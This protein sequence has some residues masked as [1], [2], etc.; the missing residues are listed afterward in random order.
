MKNQRS[1]ICLF[2]LL[3]CFAHYSIAAKNPKPKRTRAIGGGVVMSDYMF[4]AVD[5]QFPDI[6]PDIL[7]DTLLPTVNLLSFRIK[8]NAITSKNIQ[9]HPL[10]ASTSS[11][12]RIQNRSS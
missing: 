12:T 10:L 9:F 7:E 11:K 1:W 6:H 3:G 8:N 5:T 4:N 2:A